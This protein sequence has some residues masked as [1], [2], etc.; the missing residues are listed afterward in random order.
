MITSSHLATTLLYDVLQRWPLYLN[1]RMTALSSEDVGAPRAT[2]PFLVEP[3]LLDLEGGRYV[4][5]LIPANLVDLVSMRRVDGRNGGSGNGGGSSG[6]SSRGGGS[7]GGN[8]GRDRSAICGGAGVRNGGAGGDVRVQMRYESHL[9]ALSLRDVE[10]CAV[11][12]RGRPPSRSRV[13]F[14]AIS[15]TY[16]ECDGRTESVKTR[17]FPPPHTWRKPSPGC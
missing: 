2:V 17:T 8:V 6:R 12:W 9:P 15:V 13:T 10:N 3:I 1:M 7:S 4:G 16:A 11:S 14:F 5:L